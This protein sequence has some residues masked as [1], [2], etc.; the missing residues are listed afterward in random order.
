MPGDLLL[1]VPPAYGVSLDHWLSSAAVVAEV[2][3]TA[4]IIRTHANRVFHLP[5]L[6]TLVREWMQ[7]HAIDAVFATCD[8]ALLS[9]GPHALPGGR[10]HATLE[11]GVRIEWPPRAHLARRHTS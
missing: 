5:D 10:E 6:V 3:V 1:E 9:I 7:V 8:G 2:G 11:R 4:V